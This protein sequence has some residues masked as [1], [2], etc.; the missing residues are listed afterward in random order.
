MHRI[1]A[2]PAL[3]IAAAISWFLWSWLG[4][5]IDIVDVPRGHLQCLSYTPATDD[6]SPLNAKDGLFHVPDGMVERDLKILSHYT[7][8]IRTYSMLGDQGK[9]MKAAHEAGIKVMVG[10]WI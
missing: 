4:R 6:A 9:T 3:L 7:D 1:A 8:C 10:I 5:P 2:V